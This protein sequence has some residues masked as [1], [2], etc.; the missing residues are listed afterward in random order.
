MGD[1]IVLESKKYNVFLH[2][3][4][5]YSEELKMQRT[6]VNGSSEASGWRVVPYG[7]Y[8]PD[9]SNF[10][11]VITTIKKLGLGLIDPDYL[12]KSNPNL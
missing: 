4:T 6:E 8:I 1:Q 7:A 10:L 9:E 2:L 5:N 12:F 11:K 3:T